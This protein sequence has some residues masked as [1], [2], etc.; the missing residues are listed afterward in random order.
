[1]VLPDAGTGTQAWRRRGPVNEAY[2]AGRGRG[3]G[4][5]DAHPH[6]RIPR[7]SPPYGTKYPV[8]SKMTWVVGPR[9]PAT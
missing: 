4:W 2:G 5:A 6:P 1:M 9:V 3:R 7:I 8:T